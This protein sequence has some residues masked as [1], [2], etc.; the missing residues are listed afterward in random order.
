VGISGP[1]APGEFT[2]DK[3]MLH[4]TG[5]GGTPAP[6]DTSQVDVGQILRILT[7]RTKPM[8]AIFFGFLAFV[9]LLTLALPKSYTTTVKLIAG[10]PSSA[11][12]SG[13]PGAGPNS[14]LPVLNAL[15]VASGIQS[16]ETYVEL[17]QEFPVAQKVI[18]DLGLKTTPRELLHNV[19]IKPVTNT[20]II[21]LAVTWSDP[22]TSA[23]IAN[24]FANVVVDRDRELVTDQAASAIAFL[25][26]Q[27]PQSQAD[28]T[29]AQARLTSFEAAHHIVDIDEQTKATIAQLG[30]LDGKLGQTLADG[31][32][33]TAGLTNVRAQLA[34]TPATIQGD[35]TLSANP[36]VAQLQ[37]Q[38][39][40]VRVQLTTALQ[41]YTSEHPTVI[42][43]RNQADQLQREIARYQSTVVSNTNTVPNPLYQQLQQQAAQLTTQ[44][45]SDR[46]AETALREQERSIQPELSSLPAQTVALADLQ[47]QAKSAQDVYA[48]LQEKYNNAA[49]ARDTALSSVT[50]TQPASP[51]FVTMRPSLVLNVLLGALLGAVLAVLGV[52]II[53]YFD[54]TIKDGAD[55]EQELALPALAAIPLVKM[56]DGLPEIPWLRTLSIEAF[57]HLVTSIKYAT[58]APL[59]TLVVTSPIPGDGKSTIAL[60]VA[61]AMS[62]LEPRVLL[63]DADLRRPSLHVKLAAKNDRGLSD[64]LV[65]RSKFSD[66]VQR[67]RH[68]GLDV[69]ASGTPA[70]NPIKLLGSPRFD[71]LLAEA[72]NSYRF[73]VVDGTALSVNVDSAIIA[74]KVDGSMLVLS[75]NHTD[76]RAAR[77][78]LRKLHQVGVHNIL[79]YVLNRVVPNREEYRAYELEPA[80]ET[81]N[82]LPEMV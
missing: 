53:E 34:S 82:E 64:I 40:Q 23:A 9:V 62:E 13:A 77:L 80:V 28:M 5:G 18:A 69:L 73:I 61:L 38:L 65:G 25:D 41:Q 47:R 37:T 32:Q 12:G 60:N 48:A 42:G 75:T 10:N 56:R 14:D 54:N 51:L 8:L 72:K 2:Y 19:E 29:D 22:K 43:L 71:A 46:G 24:E 21:A 78:A 20:S 17:F 4:V 33:A 39:A 58:D 44:I 15:L 79:G 3:V 66:V 30:A 70:P 81:G 49:I 6:A 63:V 16:V 67:T 31:R 52:F 7:R 59:M 55:V 45:A 36:V 27:L 11:A 1:S 35:Q 57:L 50:I 68:S 26:K 74:R 76:L